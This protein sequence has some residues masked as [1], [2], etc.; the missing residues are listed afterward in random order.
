MTPIHVCVTV[1]TRKRSE[2]CDTTRASSV[3]VRQQ[4]KQGLWLRLRV[5][6]AS[7]STSSEHHVLCLNHILGYEPID[8]PRGSPT[9]RPLSDRHYVAPSSPPETTHCIQVLPPV[10][11]ESA[12]QPAGTASQGHSP[13]Y[14]MSLSRYWT[15]ADL[16]LA[17]EPTTDAAGHWHRT[18]KRSQLYDAEEWSKTY[19]QRLAPDFISYQ[20]IDDCTQLQQLITGDSLFTTS[21]HSADQSANSAELTETSSI[22]QH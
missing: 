22:Y 4:T 7:C 16:Q 19:S 8:Q 14:K 10:K 9:T 5:T 3:V 18:G 11:V 21:V 15:A 2:K 6:L 20:Y 12:E 17:F 1:V 13:D